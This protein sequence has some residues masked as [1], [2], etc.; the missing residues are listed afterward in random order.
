MQSPSS[1]GPMETPQQGTK[2]E[3]K[4]S[5]GKSRGEEG[6]LRHQRL[7]NPDIPAGPTGRGVLG[8]LPQRNPSSR[9]DAHL[10]CGQ[11]LSPRLPRTPSRG[12]HFLE[13]FM[14][15]VQAGRASGLMRNISPHCWLPLTEVCHTPGLMLHDLCFQ[16]FNLHNKPTSPI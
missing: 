13:K 7:R 11:S 15:E 14:N 8:L 6:C 10:P 1:G 2:T 12:T 4:P 9:R 5:L 16:K 3:T